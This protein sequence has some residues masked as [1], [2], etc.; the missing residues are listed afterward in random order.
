MPNFPQC[1]RPAGEGPCGCIHIHMVPLDPFGPG[2][3]KS[4]GRSSGI[5][6][7]L[8]PLMCDLGQTTYLLQFMVPHL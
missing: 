2:A 4:R 7:P 8:L 6:G 1:P 5:Q 3:A